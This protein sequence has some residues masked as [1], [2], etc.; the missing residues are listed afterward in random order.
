MTC[1]HAGDG[2]LSLFRS[3]LCLFRLFDAA[4]VHAL[5]KE[6]SIT[7]HEKVITPTQPLLVLQTVA[8]GRGTVS[9]GDLKVGD[10]VMVAGADGAIV[11]SKVYFIHDHKE[12]AQTV[13]LHH[14]KGALELTPSHMVP[15]YTEACG[16]KYCA[17]A[18]MVA[19]KEIRAGS[20]VYVQGAE[21]SVVEV[22]ERSPPPPLSPSR[23]APLPPLQTAQCTILFP[24]FTAGSILPR[25]TA[26]PAVSPGT[27]VARC[28]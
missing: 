9:V 16:A 10:S 21:T 6:T 26:G 13:L 5:Q 15:V 8:V 19:A 22:L 24:R 25:G 3:P 14:S 1:V 17:D 11:S 2:C 4:S 18:M 20:R 28:V 7:K 23:H 27:F 12:A